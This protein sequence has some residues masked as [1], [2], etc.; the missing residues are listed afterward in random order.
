M[1]DRTCTDQATP[2]MHFLSRQEGLLSVVRYT[3]HREDIWVSG[4]KRERRQQDAKPGKRLEKEWTWKYRLVENRT[5][6]KGK[7]YM[8]EGRMWDLTERKGMTT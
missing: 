3:H 6:N 1:G 2:R 8:L 5:A 7:D 4:D